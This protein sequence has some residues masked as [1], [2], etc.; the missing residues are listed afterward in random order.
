MAW[1]PAFI[2]TALSRCQTC[3]VDDRQ[4]DGSFLG[5]LFVEARWIRPRTGSIFFRTWPTPKVAAPYLPVGSVRRHL[6]WPR[7]S[8]RQHRGNKHNWSASPVPHDIAQRDRFTHPPEGDARDLDDAGR[9]RYLAD[10]AVGRG[11]SPSTTTSGQHAGHRSAAAEDR[12]SRRRAPALA[13]SPQRRQSVTRATEND[14]WINNFHGIS[15]G[16]NRH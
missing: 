10:G 13:E 5:L 4:L 15:A 6:V 1:R 9:S 11:A 16:T 7:R 2:S 14:R 12:Y 3:G 8:E